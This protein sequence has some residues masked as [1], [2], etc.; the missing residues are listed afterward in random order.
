VPLSMLLPILILAA[1]TF[2]LGLL[3]VYPLKEIMAPMVQ[4]LLPG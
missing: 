2:L 1:L 4:I 3:A